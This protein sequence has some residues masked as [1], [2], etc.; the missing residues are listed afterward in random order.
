MRS[1][2]GTQV[3]AGI[4]ILAVVLA[5]FYALLSNSRITAGIRLVEKSGGAVGVSSSL[6]GCPTQVTFRISGQQPLLSDDSLARII[7][8]LPCIENLDISGTL[9][10]DKGL[11]AIRGLSGLEV[12]DISATPISNNG[13]AVLADLPEIRDLNL[14]G[15]QIDDGS[16]QYLKNMSRLKQLRIKDTGLSTSGL[17]ML[18][19][20][21][22][23]TNIIDSPTQ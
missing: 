1:R 21:L 16:V 17:S 6:L 8:L 3:L 10:T 13:I 18:R 20:A 22:P 12:L 14:E 7:E 9:I 11:S 19:Q 23:M 15:T 2:T 5:L 4:V